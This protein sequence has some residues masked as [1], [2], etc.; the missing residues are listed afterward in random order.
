MPGAAVATT[1]SAPDDTR[2]FEIRD[3]PWSRRYS[4]SASSA[5]SVRARTS[6][7]PSGPP[8]ARQHDLVV[9]ELALAEHRGQPGLALDLDDQGRQT[10]E[11]GGASQRGADRRL[12]DPALPGHDDQPRCSEEL[13]RIHSARRPPT[14]L[15]AVRGTVAKPRRR[16]GPRRHRLAPGRRA[17]RP[18]PPGAAVA[19]ATPG[20]AGAQDA[21]APGSGPVA[22]VEVDGLLDPVL[23]DL[24][25]DQIDRAAD[26]VR[27]GARAAVR[28]R[29]RGR[30]RRR[31]RP[32]WW[33]T[34][35]GSDGPGRRV[36]R[37]RRA[38]RRPATPCG[39]LAAADLT[40]VAPGSSIEV[41]PAA[42]RRP[43]A[44]R[45]ADLGDVDVGD[46]VGAEPGGRARPG[47]QRRP[48]HPRV[49]RADSTGSRPRWSTAGASPSP[50]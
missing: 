8:P 19:V 17:G 25:D 35:E 27:A 42:A 45:R 36:G 46:R 39:L 21:C 29:R 28:Q 10:G 22:V 1:S 43:G 15:R 9:A 3:R 47:R 32:T 30:V 31:A 33:P 38:A 50:R 20:P 41:T 18:A 37:A 24:I 40:G 6:A 2:R 11:G 16:S 48:H 44:S 4:S 12:A 49:R 23:A 5:V 14:P 34:I 26:D 7:A 13:F